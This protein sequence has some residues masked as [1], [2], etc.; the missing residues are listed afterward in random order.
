MI[1]SV[2]SK[3]RSFLYAQAHVPIIR[4]TQTMRTQTLL[5]CKTAPQSVGH[6]V[7]TSKLPCCNTDVTLLSRFG[8]GTLGW[9]STLNAPPDLW[10]SDNNRPFDSLRPS[11][12]GP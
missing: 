11:F 6:L 1:S 5:F 10:T 7:R 8:I 12:S 3:R 2:S 9:K 4:E